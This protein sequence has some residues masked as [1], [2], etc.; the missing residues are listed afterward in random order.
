MLEPGWNHSAYNGVCK[1]QSV[2][3]ERG[4]HHRMKIE[5]R[6]RIAPQQRKLVAM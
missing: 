1:N 2:F 4:H 3:T 6:L 5:N